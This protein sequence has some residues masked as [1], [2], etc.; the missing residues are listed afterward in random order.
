MARDLTIYLMRL[1]SGET[2]QQIGGHFGI[3]SY[4]TVSNAIQRIKKELA[5][6]NEPLLLF[7][8][9]R[10]F[11]AKVK[12]SPLHLGKMDEKYSN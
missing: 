6:D 8:E 11:Y 3:N 2:L 9:L 1:Y 5:T 7:I 12:R 4:S 10:S